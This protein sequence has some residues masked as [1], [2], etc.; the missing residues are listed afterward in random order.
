[1]VIDGV[2]VN[3][4]ARAVAQP[5]APPEQ[6]VVIVADQVGAATRDALRAAGVGWLD[7][8]GHLYLPMTS[9]AIDKLVPP[10]PRAITEDTDLEVFGRS[11]AVLEAA[12]D[13]LMSP[14]PSGV[15]QLAREV[16]LSPASVSTARTRLREALLVS[17]DSRPL[18]PELFEAVAGVWAPRWYG[19]KDDPGG[20]LDQSHGEWVRT[21][22]IAAAMLGAPIAVGSAAAGYYYVGSAANLRE[23]RGR[24]GDAAGGEARCWLAVAPSILAITRAKEVVSHA[25]PWVAGPVT[26][27]VIVALELARDPGRGREVLTDWHLEGGSPWRTR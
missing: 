21:G 11:R 4:I 19:L 8:R 5:V 26:Q 20:P 22:D 9:P 17:S 18:T 10:L 24:F 7:R 12:L 25:V 23:S 16:S 15:R 6:P 13:L 3:V 14:R 2:T 1:M 27:A